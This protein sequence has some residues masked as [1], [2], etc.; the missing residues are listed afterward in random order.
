MNK[1]EKKNFFQEQRHYSQDEIREML[2]C[3]EDK[4]IALIRRLKEFGVLKRV[5]KENVDLQEL[6]NEDYSVAPVMGGDKISRY[7]FCFVGA[8]WVNGF[9]IKCYPKYMDPEGELTGKFKEVL[10][11]IKRYNYKKENVIHLQNDG[12]NGSSFNMLALMLY[13]LNDYYESGLYSNTQEIIQTNGTGE[14]LWDKTINETFAYIQN[15]RPLYMELKTRK[16][17][18]DET[19]FFARLHQCILGICSRTLDDQG[20]FSIFDDVSPVEFNSLELEDF[21]GE[22]YLC[23]KIEREL[24]VQFQTRKRLLLQSMYAFVKN[25]RAVVTNEHFSMFGTISYHRVWEDVCKDVLQ[26]ML[27]HNVCSI[28]P[29]KD[30]WEKEKTGF[31]TSKSDWDKVTLLDY[32]EK[33]KWN[34]VKKDTLI[35]DIVTVTNETF[36]IFDAKYYNVTLNEK[37]VY[38]QP[39]IESVTKQYLYELA[40]QKLAGGKDKINAFIF[41]KELGAAT[42]CENAGRVRL[43][44]L[45]NQ[46]LQDIHI[47]FVAPKKFYEA[48]LEGKKYL[49]DI[50]KACKVFNNNKKC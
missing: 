14:I 3:S 22:D 4:A 12:F 23:Y 37:E 21:G 15:G 33:P 17:V 9:V 31:G 7:A 35:P 40:Y 25:E 34:E 8:L 1:E 27:T 41:P 48:Y 20:L 50:L 38:G 2:G 16:R 19:D 42:V 28:Q 39:G 45:A 46:G 49:D 29:L 11:V 18:N 6:D 30:A 36:A 13:F 32:I 10:K 43:D 24:S 26:D 47:I 44:M 5:R